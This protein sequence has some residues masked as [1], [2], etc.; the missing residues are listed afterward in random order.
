MY[1]IHAEVVAA[2]GQAVQS[3]LVRQIQHRLDHQKHEG[4]GPLLCGI[5]LD[6]QPGF[7]FGSQDFCQFPDPL[8]DDAK[9]D[10]HDGFSKAWRLCGLA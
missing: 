5:V 1:R 9:I 3:F 6:A 10:A 8:V 7:E 2:L 4:G